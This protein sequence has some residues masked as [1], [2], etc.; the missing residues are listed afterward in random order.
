MQ[1]PLAYHLTWTCY[2]QWLQGDARGYVDRQHRTPG[3]PYPSANLAH[4]TA[5]ANRMSEE[6]CWLSDP[7]RCTAEAAVREAASHRSWPIHALNPQPDHVHVVIEARGVTGKRAREAL[8]SW[9][10]MQLNRR[11]GRRLHWW[12]SGGKVE[13]VLDARHLAQVVEY[14]MHKQHYPPPEPPA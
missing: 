8:K 12:T 14:V 4:Y 13:L 6:P 3:E 10:T 9:A 1:E 5:S 2:G 11:H 7:Q